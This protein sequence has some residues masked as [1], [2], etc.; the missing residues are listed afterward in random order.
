[1]NEN[2]SPGV[3]VD[4]R[5]SCGCLT[6]VGN[7]KSSECARTSIKFAFR[8]ESLQAAISLPTPLFTK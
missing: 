4:C 1:M 7:G 5:G 2:N 6:G 3:A 8:I